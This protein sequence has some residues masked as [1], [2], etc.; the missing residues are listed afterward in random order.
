MWPHAI[1]NFIP[2]K[3]I[4]ARYLS[5]NSNITLT[6]KGHTRLFSRF[7]WYR[8]KSDRHVLGC[9][10]LKPKNK[11]VPATDYQV[12][13]KKM[14]CVIQWE[15]KSNNPQVHSYDLIYMC[16]G[17]LDQHP[18]QQLKLVLR[19]T[20]GHTASLFCFIKDRRIPRS[21]QIY[22]SKKSS[23][24][25][26]TSFFYSNCYAERHTSARILADEWWVLSLFTAALQWVTATISITVCVQQMVPETRYVY[27]RRPRVEACGT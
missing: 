8:K 19:S 11:I 26:L 9:Q 20:R 6:T 25:Q 16:T 5:N 13:T 15:S 1:P 24:S 3:I 23:I 27:R 10:L 14:K 21:L 12:P 18:P 22:V 7:A 17:T 2:V 4:H